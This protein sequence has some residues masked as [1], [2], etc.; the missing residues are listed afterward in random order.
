MSAL[1]SWQVPLS[2]SV[3][4]IW[5]Q[6]PVQGLDTSSA[7][8][9]RLLVVDVEFSDEGLNLQGPG[10]LLGCAAQLSPASGVL[11]APSGTHSRPATAMC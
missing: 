2:C 5:R 9:A 11:Q 6:Q 7:G 8:H 1:P 10:L 3:S 4:D